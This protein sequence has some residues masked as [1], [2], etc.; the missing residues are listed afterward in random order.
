MT[1]DK[2]LEVVRRYRSH[3]VAMQVEPKDYPHDKLIGPQQGEDVFA[4]CCGMLPKIEIFAHEGR[5][6]KAKRWL[7]FIQGC[8]WTSG[9][10]T[11]DDLKNHNQPDEPEG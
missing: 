6:G 11:L 9:V 10:H 5:I 1:S 4:H 8:L 2:V 7:G 3:F